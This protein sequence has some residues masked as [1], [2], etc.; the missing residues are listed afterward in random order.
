M[1]LYPSAYIA[2]AMFVNEPTLFRVTNIVDTGEQSKR[3]TLLYSYTK[4]NLISAGFVTQKRKKMPPFAKIKDAS[5]FFPFVCLTNPAQ[6]MDQTKQY[7][8]NYQV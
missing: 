4:V 2:N 6:V 8:L 1:L 7:N 5:F 3:W